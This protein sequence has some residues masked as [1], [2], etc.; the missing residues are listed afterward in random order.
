MS[1]GYVK[2]SAEEKRKEIEALT[3]DMDKRVEQHFHSPEEL[4]DYLSF[5][6]KFYQY[7]MSN[8][9]L[10]QEQFFG[11]QAVGSFKFWKDKG[12]S[13]NKGEKGIKILVP[14]KTVPKFKDENG[15]WKSINKANV[16]EKKLI[17]DGKKEVTQGR[18]YFSVGHVFDVSQTNV[19]ASDLPKIFP[20]RWLE[21][22]VEDY[23]VLYK[24][25][26]AIAEK[27]G[28]SIIAPKEELGSAKGVSYTLTK[29]VALNPRNSEKQN[30]KS[31]LHELTHAKLHTKETH[32]NYTA[33]EKEFQ[34]EMTA[35]TVSSYFGIDTSSYSLDYL[36]NWTKGKTF[37]DK[38]NL[39]K[40]VHETS[41]EFIGTIE[42]TLVKER[43]KNRSLER[44]ADDQEPLSPQNVHKKLKEG[45]E[46]YREKQQKES[47]D[48]VKSVFERVRAEETYYSTQVKVIKNGWMTKEE[49]VKL[50]HQMDSVTKKDE[51]GVI[52]GQIQKE[53]LTFKTHHEKVHQPYFQK[54]TGTV[55][56]KKDEQEMER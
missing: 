54:R 18:L 50:E 29:E 40:E 38:T 24:G 52:H 47:S 39:L 2:K 6:G 25:M 9:A 26:E 30:V 3:K 51:Q 5:M 1:K 14:N 33:A 48:D 16:Q 36:S 44:E 35:Y 37:E 11:A 43:E 46:A 23:K 22:N 17:Q 45:Y 55:K 10:I 8:T 28:I 41:A 49:V 19:K 13:V 15:K 32:M 56:N 7:S 27:N 34:A 20:N 21:G 42:D 31:L 4:K 12:F 53:P